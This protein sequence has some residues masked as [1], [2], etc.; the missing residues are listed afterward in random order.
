MDDAL[1]RWAHSR[2]N[3]EITSAMRM[4][5]FRADGTNMT[6]RSYLDDAPD[7]FVRE[8]AEVVA[9]NFDSGPGSP[10]DRLDVELPYTKEPL[11][12]LETR[13]GVLF[14]RWENAQGGTEADV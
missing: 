8:R 2:L 9:V 12:R 3:G 7:D 11:D 14:R 1:F 4:V 13:D 5:V 6:F 10:L